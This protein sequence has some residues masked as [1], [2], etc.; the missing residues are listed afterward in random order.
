MFLLAQL[1][2][3]YSLLVFVAVVISWVQLPPTNPIVGIVHT[4]TEPALAPIRRLMPPVSGIDFSPM[5]LL[6]GLQALKG[7]V[8]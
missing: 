7:L 6:L 3:L 4:F 8:Y 1:I 5:I 2:D